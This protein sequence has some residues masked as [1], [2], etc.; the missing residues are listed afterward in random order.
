MLFGVAD[1][2]H[3]L[4]KKWPRVIAT[5]VLVMLAAVARDRLNLKPG[6]GA[7]FLAMLQFVA[8]AIIAAMMVVQFK[9]LVVR[10]ENHG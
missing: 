4:D 1:S 6:S 2:C 10:K 9:E 8:F 7:Y 5:F 3:F